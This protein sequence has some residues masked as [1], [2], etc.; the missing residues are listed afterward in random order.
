MGGGDYYIAVV[1]CLADDRVKELVDKPPQWLEGGLA[2]EARLDVAI[3]PEA[4][5]SALS[6][7]QPRKDRTRI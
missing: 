1:L 5:F 6:S 3:H 7:Y 4:H 2:I